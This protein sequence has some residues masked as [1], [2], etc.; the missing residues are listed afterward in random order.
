MAKNYRLIPGENNNWEVA[1]FLLIDH[2]FVSTS[3]KRIEISRLDMHSS[4]NAINFIKNLLGPL[5]YVVNK[6]L[7][8]SI[9]SA[10]TRL[11][12]DDYIICYDGGQCTLTDSGLERLQEI[13]EKYSKSKEEPI[14]KNKEVFQIIENLS[15]ETRR[16]ILRNYYEPSDDE[17]S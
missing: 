11:E 12:R 7:S 3:K 10:I 13:K 4:T 17:L 5:G 15:P 1:S 14:G 6:T 8:N 2:L 9:S 16:E